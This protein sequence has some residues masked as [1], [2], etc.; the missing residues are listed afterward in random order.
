L[1]LSLAI[2]HGT[3]SCFHNLFSAGPSSQVTI[4]L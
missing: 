2:E 4:Y 1:Y 3:M